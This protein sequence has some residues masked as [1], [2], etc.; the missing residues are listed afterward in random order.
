MPCLKA[1]RGRMV[2]A[3]LLFLA[4][5]PILA[6]GTESSPKLGQARR[7]ATA[8]ELEAHLRR[9]FKNRPRTRRGAVQGI[10]EIAGATEELSRLKPRSPMVAFARLRL[11]EVAMAMGNYRAGL[12]HYAEYLRFFPDAD[13]AY[14]A[15]LY[16]GEALYRL[17]R[18]LEAVAH[19]KEGI[20]RAPT[21]YV[22]AG[23]RYLLALTYGELKSP[24]SAAAT[25]EV[26]RKENPILARRAELGLWRQVNLAPGRTA[27]AFEGRDLRSGKALRLSDLRGKVV[28]LVFWSASS[29][30]SQRRMR[31][32]IAAGVRHAA[33]GLVVV[34]V[35]MDKDPAA[36]ARH[37]M[38]HRM[39]WAILCDGRGPA[40]A[41]PRA[42][43]VLADP[44]WLVID[45]QGTIVATNPEGRG[46]ERTILKALTPAA[47]PN[48]GK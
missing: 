6:A 47:A 8:E 36:V 10:A 40:G 23:G 4:A 5:G 32:W 15:H 29:S 39:E 34:G 28:L 13:K 44:L 19:L 48:T 35:S 18:H 37:V 26:L 38:K 11:G 46:L 9:L 1:P 24:E 16:L 25:I 30:R 22:R 3:L 14:E 12:V 43:H 17:R 42:Y 27:P 21:P 20:K 31:G 41:A 45:R 2:L 33:D 7:P